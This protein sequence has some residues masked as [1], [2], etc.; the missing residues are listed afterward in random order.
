MNWLTGWK[1][2]KKITVQDEF[3]DGDLTNFP[4]YVKIDTDADFHEARADGHDIRFTLPDGKTLLK[5]ECEH[6]TGGDGNPATAHFWVK[7]PSILADGGAVIYIYYGKS[8]A[9]DGEDASN[10]WDANFK[11][12]WHMKDITPSTVADSTGVNDGTKFAANEPIEADG[13]VYKGQDFD[14]GNDYVDLTGFTDAGTTHTFAFWV[15][16]HDSTTDHKFLF[17]TETGRLVIGWVTNTAGKIGV[18]DGAWRKFGNSPS[19]NTWHHVVFVLN[20][21][22]GKMKMYLNGSQYGAELDYTPL[23]IGGAVAIGSK[24]SGSPSNFNGLIDEVRISNIA[25]APAWVKF[26]HHNINETDNEIS[27]GIEE[28]LFPIIFD[29]VPR[30]RI[31]DV[32]ARTRIHNVPPRARIFDRRST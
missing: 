11:A 10:V 25:R 19:I 21:A 9:P 31:L 29:V 4:A 2:R 8:D 14:G 17:D 15:Y 30:Q 5:Y 32:E 3:V 7:I 1:Y 16:S 22:T 23:A 12:V 26:E 24:F 13:K 6:W 20:G 27:W 28:S 18:Y